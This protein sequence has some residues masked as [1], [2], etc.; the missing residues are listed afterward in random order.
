MGTVQRSCSVLQALSV[1]HPLIREWFNSN[2]HAPTDIQTEAWRRTAEGE[3]LLIC[4]PTGSGKTL[5]AF[6]WAINSLIQGKFSGKILYI[7]PMKA[8]NNDILRNLDRPLKEITELAEARDMAIREIRTGIRSGDSSPAERARLNKFPPDIFVTTPETL[9]IMLTSRSGRQLLS[10]VG[11]VILD[12]IHVIA[13]SKR[14]TLLMTN[15]ERLEELTPMGTIQRLGISATVRPLARVASFLGGYDRTFLPRPVSVISDSRTRAYKLEI[16]LGDGPATGWW[17]RQI[18]V[19]AEEILNHSSSILFC[20]SRRAAEKAAMLLNEYF[21]DTLV[22]AHHGSLS[23]EYRNWVEQE[24]KAGHLKAVAATSTLE[25]GI[26][27]GEVDRVILLQAPFS[28][29]SAVQRIGRSN[30][31]L[32][33]ISSAVFIPLHPRETLSAVSIYRAVLRGVIEDVNIPENCLDILAQIIISETSGR[34]ISYDDLYSI[35]KR[36]YPYRNLE[37][38]HFRNII[39]MLAG[40]FESTRIRELKPRL[41]LSRSPSP[42]SELRLESREGLSYLIYSSGGT[43]PDRGYFDLRIRGSNE[44]IGEL[45]EEFVFERSL[46][47]RFTLGNRV[48]KI[49]EMD[50]RSVHVSS[51]RR[52]A[53]LAPFWRADAL[54]VDPL[55]AQ[56]TADELTRIERILDSSEEEQSRISYISDLPEQVSMDGNSARELF[57]WVSAQRKLSD[58]SSSL[59]CRN[60]IV[61]EE[62]DD[63]SL[64]PDLIHIV[65]HNLQGGRMNA[66]LLM[67]MQIRFSKKHGIRLTG[68]YNDDAVI[69]SVP[70]EYRG[71]DPFTGLDSDSVNTLLSDALPGSG[72][73]GARFRVNA[74]RALLILKQGFSQRTPLWLQRM[75]SKQLLERVYEMKDFPI[76]NETWRELFDHDLALNALKEHLDRIESDELEITRIFTGHPSP[77]SSDIMWQLNNEYLYADDRM[78]LPSPNGRGNGMSWLNTLLQSADPL[79]DIPKEIQ[80]EYLGKMRRL[81]SEYLP[82]GADELVL[83][84]SDRRIMTGEEIAELTGALESNGE[85]ADWNPGEA[86]S[87]LLEEEGIYRKFQTEQLWLHRSCARLSAAD[88]ALEWMGW[89][90]IVPEKRFMEIWGSEVLS[91]IRESNNLLELEAGKTDGREICLDETLERLLRIRRR[92]TRKISRILK[93]NE[94]QE[95]NRKLQGI[96]LHPIPHNSDHYPENSGAGTYAL[97]EQ[98]GEEERYIRMFEALSGRNLKSELLLRGLF[99]ARLGRMSTA[100]AEGIFRQLDLMWTC[101]GTRQISFASREDSSQYFEWK[102]PTAISVENWEL[103]S[104]GHVMN[105]SFQAMIM[106]ANFL[107]SSKKPGSSNSA[108]HGDSKRSAALRLW[109]TAMGGGTLR[110]DRRGR[111][112]STHRSVGGKSNRLDGL[113]F[114]VTGSPSLPGVFIPVQP[115]RSTG[116]SVGESGGSGGAESVDGSVSAGNNVEHKLPQIPNSEN[117]ASSLEREKDKVYRLFLRHG[118]LDRSTLEDEGKAFSWRKML[119]TL[120]LMELSGEIVG[121]KLCD[122]RSGIQFAMNE[123]FSRSTGKYSGGTSGKESPGISNGW[124]WV[125]AADPCI[126]PEMLKG[127]RSL[128]SFLILISFGDIS[129][130][131]AEIQANGREI[132]L[133]A[134]HSLP[135]QHSSGSDGEELK[136]HTGYQIIIDFYRNHLL[137]LATDRKS[138]TIEQIESAPAESHE[139]GQLMIQQGFTP[140]PGGGIKLWKY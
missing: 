47:D 103:L 97:R 31:G 114:S 37:E 23:R 73:F 13:G 1:F 15:L 82:T 122:Q 22:F 105:D 136:P 93:I 48:W 41:M 12:E 117:P 29:S 120:R 42:E 140:M 64:T 133:H 89:Q 68:M 67:C 4:A 36:S 86:F 20:N 30:H 66:A 52:S 27:I 62:L 61:I 8:L 38:E 96:Q 45:D 118:M 80:T 113:N 3:N 91:E 70:R 58:T 72:L 49:D 26:D 60:R 123:L 95:S 109:E 81:I 69:L 98:D 50:N 14:G 19:M 76:T 39:E 126:L 111:E 116:N 34:S 85:A 132:N 59:P 87:Q 138:I 125:N 65:I 16:K 21:E 9:N 121:G 71:Y 54:G 55:M 77:F 63:P 40:R 57:S 139:L 94:L 129:V 92:N 102:E 101:S 88:L 35:I 134:S 128:H 75:R 115:G 46:G 100:L 131:I 11:M 108:S 112:R 84:L 28:L 32:K 90:A 124:Y 74:S 43:I 104:K 25:L 99:Q 5:S 18:P 2:F 130:P 56:Q 119:P 24:L 127:R 17:E 83:Y 106:A 10:D 78:E 6:L 51:T 79:P 135:D 44:K 110:A 7:S 107:S 53:M 33:G 137:N